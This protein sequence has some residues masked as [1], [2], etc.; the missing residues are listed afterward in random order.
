MPS[1]NCLV[2]AATALP[3]N[4]TAFHSVKA[5]PPD[6]APPC[7]GASVSPT[8]S[9]CPHISSKAWHLL[10]PLPAL[11]QLL[12]K[13]SVP[14]FYSVNLL[15]L[16]WRS[17]GWPAVGVLPPSSLPIL[18][19]FMQPAVPSLQCLLKFLVKPRFVAFNSQQSSE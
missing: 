1:P 8:P 17:H 7:C 19:H 10:P 5:C 3:P 11:A 14:R 9:S 15:L 16:H 6:L 18:L 13:L 2:L 12:S 4:F